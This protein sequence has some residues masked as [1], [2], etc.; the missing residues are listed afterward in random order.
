MLIADIESQ[1]FVELAVCW[2]PSLTA[3]RRFRSRMY[4]V[5]QGPLVTML[6][7]ATPAVVQP[8]AQVAI[9]RAVVPVAERARLTIWIAWSFA[10]I[11]SVGLNGPTAVL[12][13][14]LLL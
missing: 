1:V 2:E 8:V 12:A 4:I 11:V 9:V 7:G 3:V 13:V 10:A 5:A 14:E 6:A